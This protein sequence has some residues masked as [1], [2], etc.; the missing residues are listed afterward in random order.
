MGPKR[1]W[2]LNPRSVP[3]W[4]VRRLHRDFPSR[5]VMVRRGEPWFIDYQGGRRGALQYD[6]ASLLMN[7]K[8]APPGAVRA[9]LLEHYLD[10]LAERVPVD[11]AR[12]LRYY[13]A[14]VLVRIL[15]ALG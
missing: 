12:F 10:A 4:R 3:G 8:A 15:Q 7:A 14:H 5:N 11:R 6:V 1:R 13:P 9:A 2:R